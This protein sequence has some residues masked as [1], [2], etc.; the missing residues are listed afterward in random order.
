VS[1]PSPD[2]GDCFRPTIEAGVCRRV[3]GERRFGYA[4]AD[5][6]PTPTDIGELAS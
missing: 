2:T 3:L 1:E 4:A 6:A 5:L